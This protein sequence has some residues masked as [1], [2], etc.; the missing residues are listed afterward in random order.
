[1]ISIGIIKE[2]SPYYDPRAAIS[3]E[4]I[5][6]I[7][8]EQN[9]FRFVVQP[10]SDRVFSDSEYEKAGA[11][12]NE[13]L[14]SCDFIFGIKQVDPAA[15]LE[16]KTYF[17]FAHVAKAQKNNQQYLQ[18]LKQKN[19]ILIDY[20]YLKNNSSHR[21]LQFGNWAGEAGVFYLLKAIEKKYNCLLAN[22]TQLE[23]LQELIQNGKIKKLPALKIILT[24]NGKTAKGAINILEKLNITSVS[25]KAYLTQKFDHAVYCQLTT[26]DYLKSKVGKPF[27]KQ[28]FYDQPENYIS[29]FNK[30]ISCSDAFLACHY[31]SPNAPRFFEKEAIQQPAFNL[32]I[33][34]D[35]SCDLNGPIPTTIKETSHKN[36]FYDYNKASHRLEVPFSDSKHITVASIGNLP[37][38]FARKTS[39][40]FSVRLKEIVLPE[41][42]KK[43]SELLKNATITQNIAAIN[44]L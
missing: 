37:A 23:D 41:L 7:N 11:E 44:I 14:E 26:S 17:F 20:E 39:N 8:K 38:L 24:G 18:I 6:Q 31:W 36:P 27:N 32:K 33:I 1:M 19:I 43:E 9:Q 2:S 40:Y 12:L 10:S 35:V 29:D 4:T 16:N 25:K 22:Y 28:E 15:L 42:L 5:E 30:F 13:S 3:P 21:L 34:I